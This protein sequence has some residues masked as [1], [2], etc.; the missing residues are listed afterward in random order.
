MIQI[1]NLTKTFGAFY[2]LR[3]INLTIKAGEFWIIVGPN[4][5]GKTTL[6]KILATLSKPS[7][8]SLQFAG[9]N[10]QSDRLSIRRKIG[11]IGHQSFLY[12]NLSAEE[13]LKFYARLYRLQSARE[14]I[15][16]RLAQVGLSSRKDDLV[17]NF[18]RGMQQRLTIARAL[19]TDPQIVLLDEPYSGLDQQGLELFS[20]L[21]KKL[22]APERILLM[23][24]H[25]FS[26]GLELATHYAMLKQGTLVEQD[27]CRAISVEQ[28]KTKYR[29]LTGAV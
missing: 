12:P 14:L 10:F 18:S 29:E 25:N 4:G 5:A 7:S 24:T 16:T 1:K 27:A 17:R 13:N 2:A 15:A 26:L 3:N 6:L 19:L 20:E 9:F 11:F 8:G 22:V 23:T 28:F 21:L